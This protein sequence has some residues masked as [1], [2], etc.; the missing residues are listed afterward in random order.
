MIKN[1][2]DV[3]G[4]EKFFLKKRKNEV[5]G[6][7]YFVSLMRMIVNFE[8][9]EYLFNLVAPLITE[10]DTTNYLNFLPAKSTLLLHFVI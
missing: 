9:F 8:R 4:I 6:K 5:N 3:S 2:R 1:P 7:I 10:Q